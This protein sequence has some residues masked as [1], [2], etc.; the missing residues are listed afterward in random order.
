MDRVECTQ[1]KLIAAVFEQM[2]GEEGNIAIFFEHGPRHLSR[3]STGE[4]RHNETGKMSTSIAEAYAR[5]AMCNLH[6][7]IMEVSTH[8][9][10][11]PETCF[12]K[13]IR[14]LHREVLD[15]PEN[16]GDPS[17]NSQIPAV[18]RFDDLVFTREH[19]LAIDN[20]EGQ[21]SGFIAFYSTNNEYYSM[22]FFVTMEER[23]EGWH[24]VL[25]MGM[26]RA[27]R[28]VTGQD[29][30]QRHKDA[31]IIF[32]QHALD[33]AVLHEY[34]E[35]EN[36]SEY[37]EQILISSGYAA[38]L[39]PTPLVG[40]EVYLIPWVGD[41]RFLFADQSANFLEKC[42]SSVK[43]YAHP[44]L[45]GG[46]HNSLHQAV[47]DRENASQAVRA[48]FP[49]G[50]SVLR[51][52]LDNSI[53]PQEYAVYVGENF[54]EEIAFHHGE[55]HAPRKVSMNAHEAGSL[56][57]MAKDID[58][59]LVQG[60]IGPSRSVFAVNLA[61]GIDLSVDTA[62]C[63]A[64]RHTCRVLFVDSSDN[65]KDLAWQ[66]R[67]SDAF[68]KYS[69][70]RIKLQDVAPS[71]DFFDLNILAQRRALISA[72]IDT[73]AEV[74]CLDSLEALFPAPSAAMRQKK[75]LSWAKSWKRDVAKPVVCCCM[76]DFISPSR[77]TIVEN[78]ILLEVIDLEHST[79]SAEN[80]DYIKRTDLS[81]GLLLEATIEKFKEIPELEK[82]HFGYYLPTDPNPDRLGWRFISLTE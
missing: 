9:G 69:V 25:K 30:M 7:A 64:R 74:L 4:W 57:L 60:N 79:L 35:R 32:C 51:T 11:F 15:L 6:V 5:E 29:M 56:S 70:A 58:I 44:V 65:E 54:K 42:G 39:D 24:P 34:A 66:S 72:F 40:R 62:L 21:V 36:N 77:K 52:I 23:L 8:L 2:L 14:P 33:A 80:I 81:P 67:L 43:I 22:P 76:R 50:K 3:I 16:F 45:A 20:P 41:E 31:K 27:H 38:E 19:V 46:E 48:A 49:P 59:T 71:N 18:C 37:P 68:P 17:L 28:Q 12:R 78:S 82:K 73:G 61:V 63:F 55:G 47:F 13:I 1:M 53:T 10:H 75:F 26:S